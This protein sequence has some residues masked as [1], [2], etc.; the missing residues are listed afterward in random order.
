MAAFEPFTPAHGLTVL[1][2]AA[3]MLAAVVS[4]RRLRHAEPAR[5]RRWERAA[6]A[7]ALVHWLLYAAHALRFIRQD[8]MF[9]IPLQLCDLASLLA[10]LWLLWPARR[11][12]VLV[13][14]WGIALSSQ[15]FVTPTVRV[16]PEGVNFWFFWVSHT[17]IVG[18]GIYACAVR[19]LV[20]RGS[21]LG[22]AIGAG[23]FYLAI[24]LPLNVAC[25]MN[26]GYTGP[27]RADG[28]RTLADAL[29]QWPLRVVWI[30][31]LATGAMTVAWLPWGI[32]ARAGRT[33]RA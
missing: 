25:D 5:L 15:G 3:V 11:L 4:G 6:G 2:C 22:D 12:A 24:T 9:A 29:G 14:F 32:A 27:P 13:Y 21:D 31:L 23:V 16:G 7:F 19:G 28:A 1:V 30:V 20:P 26:F 8:P 18:T 33:T 17:I 10:A